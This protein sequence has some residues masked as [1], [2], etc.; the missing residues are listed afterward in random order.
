MVAAYQ[1][2]MPGERAL[3]HRHTPNALR[4]VLEGGPGIYT[5]VDGVRIDMEP[6]D[7][8]LT[9]GWCWHGHGNDGEDPGYWIDYLDVPLVDLLEPMFFEPH[10]DGFESVESTT[11]DSPYVFPFAAVSAALAATEPDAAGRAVHLLD[12]PSLPTMRLSMTSLLDAR[13][14]LAP[15]ER[16]TANQIVSVVEGA[17]RT[18]IDGQAHEWGRGDVL[19]IPRWSWFRHETDGPA[20]LF[21]VSDAPVLE[22][23]G[24]WRRESSHGRP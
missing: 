22:K 3:S 16:S 19:A 9:P 18:V 7:V 11:R 13:S 4:L 20:V 2:I 15:W 1:G 14:A 10:P 24:F 17:G 8:V 23:L 21:A 5:V 12:A 6:G